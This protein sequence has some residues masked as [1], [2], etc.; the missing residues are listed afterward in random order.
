MNPITIS[1]LPAI[2]RWQPAAWLRVTGSDAASFLQGQFTNDLKK[3]GAIYGLWLNV[4]GKVLADSFVVPGA[5][6]GEFWIGSYF[7]SATVIKERLESFI[8]ADDVVV[9]DRTA[10]WTGLSILGPRAEEFLATAPSVGVSFRGRREASASAEWVLPRTAGEYARAVFSELPELSGEDMTLRRIAA[11]I[12][13]VPAEI[14][15]GDLPNEGGLD[16]D[17]VSYTKGCYLGQEVMARL[18]S[19]GQVRRRLLRVRGRGVVPPVLPA[20]LFV[21]AKQAGELRSAVADRDGGYVGCALLSLITLGDRRE[22]A[23]T[24]EG[25]ATVELAGEP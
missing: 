12:P 15:P 20:P 21:G 16:G 1:T 10:E 11:G 8:I 3:G 9:E 5:S 24:A 23:C 7:S 19:I 18:K 2:F 14:G 17:A 4:K 22:L 13:A 25:A 6:A